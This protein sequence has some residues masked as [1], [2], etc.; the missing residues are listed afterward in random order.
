ME[1][2][3]SVV[4]AMLLSDGQYLEIESPKTEIPLAR[5]AIRTL[6]IGASRLVLGIDVPTSTSFI[7]N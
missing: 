3:Q 4:P 6:E 2:P 5:V 1:G 7:R